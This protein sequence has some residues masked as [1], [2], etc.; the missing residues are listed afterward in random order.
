MVVPIDDVQLSES[1]SQDSLADTIIAMVNFFIG[2]LGLAAT[3]AFVYAGVLW[4][5]SAGNEDSITKARK[6]M[7]Y[8]AL[9]ILVVILSFSAVRFIAGS[10]GTGPSGGQVGVGGQCQ[11][12]SDCPTGERCVASNA[13]AGERVCVLEQGN[14]AVCRNNADCP[15]NF[16]CNTSSQRCESQNRPGVSGSPS[17]PAVNEDIDQI[18]EA[19][20]GLQESLNISNLSQDDQ[21]AIEGVLANRARLDD[22]IDNLEQLVDDPNTSDPL[23]RRLEAFISG[24]EQLKLI[25]QVLDELRDNMPESAQLIELY[26]ETSD[27]LDQLIVDPSSGTLHRRFEAKYRSLKE[28]IQKFPVV[29]A[30]IKALPGEGNVPF[31]VQLDGLDSL[32]PTGG[33]ISQYRWSYLDNS[34]REISLDSAPVILHEFTEANTFVVKLRVSTSQLDD[35]GFKTAMDGVSTLRI[36][37]NP[38]ASKVQFRINGVE[39][40]DVFHVTM[41][42]AQ[43]GLSFDPSITVPALGRTI[44]K[45]EWFFGDSASDV[46]NVPT[47]VV[48]TYRGAG[49]YVVKWITTDSLQQKD[50]RIVKLFV[51]SW[52]LRCV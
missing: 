33:T 21:V 44:Q 3:L 49:E 23:R 9:G 51:K 5:L 42:E 14:G 20:D 10:A 46:R 48:H 40:L 16:V 19:L 18:D 34:G 2:F 47:T 12:D 6:I 1:I 35:Q 43:A 41:R 7:T 11:L 30:R 22:K 36:R 8:A 26:N 37:A 52:L 50:S 4:V 39:A 32:D 28:L 31:S 24:L 15:S 45:Y 29:Q 13:N 38:P 17:E 25:R 27:L